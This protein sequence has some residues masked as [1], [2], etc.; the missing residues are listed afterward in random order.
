MTSK[1]NPDDTGPN[2]AHNFSVRVSRDDVTSTFTRGDLSSGLTERDAWRVFLASR[3]LGR[4]EMLRGSV[5]VARFIT[6]A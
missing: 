3:V 2:K 6:P 5:V 4:V 1:K